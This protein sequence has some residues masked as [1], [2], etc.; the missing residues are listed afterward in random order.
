MDK[1]LKEIEIKLRAINS[2]IAKLD[3]AI[4]LAAFEVLKPLLLGGYTE[5]DSKGKDIPTAKEKGAPGDVRD[6]YASFNPQKP[7]ESVLVLTG[8]LYTQRGSSPFSLEELRGLF[9]DVGVS[10]PSRIDMTLRNCARNGKKLFQ[11]AGQGDYRPT[12]HGENYFKSE[13]SL[14]PGK[15][16]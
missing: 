3:P 11:R 8:W 15:K 7:A 2:I 4:K 6:F 1:K 12:V 9:D 5:L 10:M 13:M 14:K 16:L